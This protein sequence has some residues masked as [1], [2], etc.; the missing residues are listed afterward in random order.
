MP[1]IKVTRGSFCKDYFIELLHTEGSKKAVECNLCQEGT[2]PSP[3]AWPWQIALCESCVPNI[4][5]LHRC[6]RALAGATDVMSWDWITA[7]HNSMSLNKYNHMSLNKLRGVLSSGEFVLPI[8]T[9]FACVSLPF[10]RRWHTSWWYF[11]AV[12]ESRGRGSMFR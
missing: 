4:F 6:R 1:E 11:S 10:P 7:A 12:M 3:I 2:Y 9:P 5:S 8:V